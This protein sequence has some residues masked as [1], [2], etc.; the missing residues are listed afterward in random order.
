M[1]YRKPNIAIIEDND[2]LR[3]DI[4][5]FLSESGY[6]VW[7]CN[8][9]EFFWRQLHTELTDIVLVDVSLPGEDGIGVVKHLNLLKKYG[10]IIITARGG[11]QDKL[12]G[13]QSGA[14][15]YL[16]KPINFLMLTEKIDTLW[17]RICE[18]GSDSRGSDYVKILGKSKNIESTEK[19][20]WV[21]DGDH[22][23]LIT[24]DNVLVS[25]SPKEYVFLEKL[26]NY[27]SQVFS[28]LDL[29]D[30]LF[31]YVDE[32][33]VHRVDVLLSRLRTKLKLKNVKLPIRTLF[34]KGVVFQPKS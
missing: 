27:P 1:I 4:S 32:V 29:H 2:D 34:G 24:P 7:S 31:D 20:N 30:I 8:S 6:K 9:A 10:L 21:L 15:L 19:T 22:Y 17:D 16:V 25:L 18:S 28:K 12:N 26:M 33:D 5:F 13:L 23:K 11:Q 14:D 3:D